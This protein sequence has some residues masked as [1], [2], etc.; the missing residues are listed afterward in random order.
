MIISFSACAQGNGTNNT[1][2]ENNMRIKIKVGNNEFTA[3]VYKNETTR[4]IISKLP[5]T[6]NMQ[7]LDGNEKYYNFLENLLNDAPQ[8]FGTMNIGNIMLWSSNC[9]VLF[10]KTFSTSYRYVKIGHI[11]NVT[12]LENAL[13][14]GNAEISFL[15][16]N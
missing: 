14:S 6:I 11:E 10:N 12:G 8:S 2:G 16:I 3:I 7:K 15:I 9:L 5:V 13:G 1:V 4:N